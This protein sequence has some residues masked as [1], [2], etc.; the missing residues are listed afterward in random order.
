MIVNPEQLQAIILD[1]QKHDY[2]NETFK[3][4]DKSVET[5][6]S[7]KLLDIQLDAKLNYSHHVRNICKF[8]DQLSALIKLNNFSCFESKRV[9]I[10][11]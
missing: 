7:V 11:S 4:N 2:S 10:K 8:S 9:L 3:F 5:V 1:K 6:S